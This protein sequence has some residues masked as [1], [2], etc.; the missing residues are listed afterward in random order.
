[1]ITEHKDTDL[2][3]ITDEFCNFFDTMMNKVS[4]TAMARLVLRNEIIDHTDFIAKN[5]AHVD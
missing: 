5:N 4:T 2:F 3:W 1:M